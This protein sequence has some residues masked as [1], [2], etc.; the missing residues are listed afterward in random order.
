MAVPGAIF[1]SR[2]SKHELREWARPT[3]RSVEMLARFGHAAI[4]LVYGLFGALALQAA[5]GNG[6]TP[7]GSETAIRVIGEQPFGRVLLGVTVVGLASYVLW[8]FVQAITDPD[9]R[10]SDPKGYAIRAGYIISGL[11]YAALALTT[12]GL[13][14]GTGS[15]TGGDTSKREWTAW[16]MDFPL[17]RWLVGAVGLMIAGVGIAHFIQVYTTRFMGD[18]DLAGM[19]PRVRTWAKRI[20]QFG[21]GARGVTFLIIAWFLVQAAWMINV[22]EVTGLGGALREIAAQSDG[23]WL[24]AVVAAGFIAYGMHCLM[25]ARYRYYNVT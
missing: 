20:G 25:L 6:G 11:A 3:N 5:F 10:G 23:R 8:R 19:E 22:R 9:N 21:L 16:L 15:A 17:G 2:N 7:Q 1:A 12:A 24:F 13:A 18:Y 14:L 4:G